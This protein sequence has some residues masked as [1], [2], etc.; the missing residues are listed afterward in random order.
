MHEAPTSSSDVIHEDQSNAGY[1]T[2][3]A[4]IYRQTATRCLQ[5]LHVCKQCATLVLALGR[6]SPSKITCNDSS[7]MCCNHASRH[8]ESR[9]VAGRGM[10]RNFYQSLS[11]SSPGCAVPK[12]LQRVQMKRQ[13]VSGRLSSQMNF[14]W[15]VYAGQ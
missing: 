3:L 12:Q 7:W 2:L 11:D 8:A 13:R 9:S 15:K 10:M 4:G 14:P 6:C 5:R 1:D